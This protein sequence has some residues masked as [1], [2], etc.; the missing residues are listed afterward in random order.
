MF[1]CAFALLSDEIDE[2]WVVPSYRHPFGKAMAPFRD[3]IRMVR[4]AMRPLGAR[5][6]VSTTEKDNEGPGYTYETLHRLRHAHPGCRFRLIVGSD[7]LH[8]RRRWHR[9]ADVQR[10]AP[11]LIVPRDGRGARASGFALPDVSSTRLRH[12]LGRR[13]SPGAMLPASVLR[14]V[15]ENDLYLSATRGRMHSGPCR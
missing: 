13:A 1:A 3:R 14:Y 12:L 11:L 4:L 5:V 9:F 8:E 2:V 7:I 6:K 15:C 10:L